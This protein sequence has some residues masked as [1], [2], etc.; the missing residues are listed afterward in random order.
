M[1]EAKRNE[2][3]E[4]RIRT[5]AKVKE[6]KASIVRKSEKELYSKIRTINS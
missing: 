3:D 1:E 6:I 4:R 5:E 2:L